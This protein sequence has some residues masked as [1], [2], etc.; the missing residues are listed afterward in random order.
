MLKD[1]IKKIKYRVRNRLILLLI[2][3]RLAAIGFNIRLYYLTQEFLFDEIDLNL[4]PELAPLEADF[5]SSSEIKNIYDHPENKLSM[6]DN[7]NFI[8]ERCLCFAL[9]YNGEILT[10][11]WCNLDRCHGLYPFPLK[12]DEAYLSG[13]FTFRAYRGKNLAPFLRY[14]VYKHLNQTGKTRIYSLTDVF[15]TPAIKFKNK[16]KAK[17][18]K[19]II[20]IMFFNKY[21]WNFTIGS[22]KHFVI[23][24]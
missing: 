24:M 7:K 22:P 15:N 16:L 18:L 17:P 1:I 23:T 5:L 2:F 11:L 14:Q 10:Y 20:N 3:E 21:N 9:K 13:A 8:E 6:R 19:I 4:K 12:E